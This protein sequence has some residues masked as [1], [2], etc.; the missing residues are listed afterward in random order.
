MAEIRGLTA[1]VNKLRDLAAKRTADGANPVVAV[2]YTAAYAIHVHENVEMKWRGF[3][4]NMI[5]RRGEDGIAY[6]GYDATS[7]WRGLFWGPAGQAKFLEAPARYL[8]DEMGNIVA[9]AMGA[10]KTM[11]QGLLLAG[12]RLQ[13]ESQGLVPIDTGNLRASAFTRL[14]SGEPSNAIT[15]QSS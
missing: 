10:G 12:L 8:Q 3:P 13:R 5:V 7:K 2:G 4:R 14:E 15:E 11:A 6:T 1:V 9:K